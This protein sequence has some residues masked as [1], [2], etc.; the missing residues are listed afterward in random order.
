VLRRVLAVLAIV[1]TVAGLVA[2]GVHMLFGKL[3]LPN[4]QESRCDLTGTA[5]SVSTEQA[6]N[7]ATVTAIAVRRRLPSRAA[8]IALA[9]ALQESKLIN[10][11]YGDLDSVGLFQQ[12]PSQGWGSAGQIL[13]PRYAAGKFY[14]RLL[15]VR[16]WQTR[17]L[18]DVAQ[19]VQQSRF[20]E[21]YA[22]WEDEATALARA[23]S[24]AT[25]AGVSCRF[26]APTVAARP[27]RV[28]EL[29]GRDLAVTRL[30]SSER[31]VDMRPAT[32]QGWA[33]A[34]WLV[35]HADRLGIDAIRHAGRQWTRSDGWRDAA[36]VGSDRIRVELADIKPSS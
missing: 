13:D 20:P 27:T 10:V 19:T 29:L 14:D 8:V 35:A 7:A 4:A 5:Y 15:R 18:S 32:G 2:L 11:E 1:G 3:D 12:R 17:P 34:S 21:A 26:P 31:A 23:L 22:Q 9:T 30:T 6:A 24:G 28:A 25:A 36:G 33:A 16:Q